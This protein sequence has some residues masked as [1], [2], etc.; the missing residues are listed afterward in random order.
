ML[1]AAVHL[2]DA[3]SMMAGF[4]TGSDGLKYQIGDSGQELFALS[5]AKL[6][7][8]QIE[9]AQGFDKFEQSINPGNQSSNQ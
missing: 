4:D 6:E 2:G 5:D 1:V 8:L 7:A 9:A 3:L